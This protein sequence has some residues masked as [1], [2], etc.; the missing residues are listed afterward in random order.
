MKQYLSLI[1]QSVKNELR[2][3]GTFRPMLTLLVAL[4]LIYPLTVAF[5]YSANTAMERPAVIID[6]D[7]SAL[8]RTFTLWIDAT[9]DVEIVKRM[10]S[11]QDGWDLI[12]R[13]QVE[14]LIF[15]PSDFS[16]RLKKGRQAA[17]KVWVNSANIYTL[18]TSLP[19]LYGA[20]G[21]MS[22]A[23]SAKYMMSKGVSPAIV[24]ARAVP[25]AT[26][27]RNLFLPFGGY[28]EFF[29]P[30][31]IMTVIQQLMLI[32]L[33]FS[34]GYQR[35]NGLLKISEPFLFSRI[36]AKIWVQSPFYILASA[37]VA[38]IIIPAFG[39]PV[40]SLNMCMVLFGALL[41]TL[42]PFA[43]ILASLMKDHIMALE[44]LMFFSAPLFLMSGFTWP[45][46]Q[47]PG[48]LQQIA[49]AFPITPA[50]QALR[51]VLTK[52]SD[53]M[54]LAPYFFWMARL[55]A[56]YTVLALV[57][58]TLMSQWRNLMKLSE[59]IRSKQPPAPAN[60]PQ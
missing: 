55:F 36:A 7:N 57:L 11:V 49:S 14:M 4:P 6:Q 25:I 27:K 42:A 26:D 8:S 47:M 13:H 35:K 34:V 29:A 10:N 3:I 31:I 51:I 16:T 9:Q 37:L 30:G 60:G 52:S 17:Y 24:A 38:Y 46:D 59:R 53:W 39:W 19:G 54:D 23:I 12:R 43:M 21:T 48:Y 2:V 40:T 18:G 15:I 33:G 32:C 5:L 1:W 45:M 58:L 50:L 41:I 28:G 20:A 22:A 44:I 56:E